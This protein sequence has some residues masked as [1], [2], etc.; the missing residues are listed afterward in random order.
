MTQIHSTA[1]VS[2]KAR[3]GENVSIGPYV[4][5]E[6][7]VEIGNDC[8]IGPHVV[9]YNGARIGNKITIHQGASISHIPQDLK[10]A[11]EKT[12][13][14]VGD[15][16]VIHEFVTLHRGT[17]ETGHTHIGKNCLFMAYSHVAHDNEIG[18][19]CI[20]A[21]TVQLAGHVHIENYVILGGGVLVH[22]FTRI[23]QH[24]MVGGGYRVSQDV[25][26]FI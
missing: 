24:S 6:D 20:L 8:K 14:H 19:N 3:I 17:K 2:K 12:Y 25:P 21:N 4:I 11:N 15:G 13:L 1:L 18:D 26:P 16:C 10:F 7:D 5:V 23:G 9:I 22:Q